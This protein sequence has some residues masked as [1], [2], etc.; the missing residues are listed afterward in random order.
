MKNTLLMTVMV[1]FCI[2]CSSKKQAM[3]DRYAGRNPE[4]ARAVL[5]CLGDLPRD[6]I[7]IW[8]LEVCECVADYEADTAVK[9]HKA[10]DSCT[11]KVKVKY[12]I[13]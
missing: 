1:L 8:F 5:D 2:A 4:W 7:P 13:E 6:K 11:D 10:F 12:G 3:P 9:I